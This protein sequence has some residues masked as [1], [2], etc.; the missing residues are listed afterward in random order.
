MHVI[1]DVQYFMKSSA[2]SDLFYFMII[3]ASFNPGELG[4]KWAHF[5]IL[6]QGRV[7]WI[8]SCNNINNYLT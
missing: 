4:Q 8:S 1:M 5:I 2:S 3:V 7:V 6:H